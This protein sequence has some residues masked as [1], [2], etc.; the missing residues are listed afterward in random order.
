MQMGNTL[1]SVRAVV[2]DYPVAFRQFQFL[3]HMGGNQQQVTQQVL[4]L[5]GGLTD[6]CKRFFRDDQKMDGSLRVDIMNNECLI[7]LINDLGGNI[8]G[9]AG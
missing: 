5:G 7:I 4:V 1:T 8:A 6:P 2:D 9:V 3:R